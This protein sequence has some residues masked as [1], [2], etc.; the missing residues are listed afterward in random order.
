MGLPTPVFGGVRPYLRW[1][2][3]ARLEATRRPAGSPEA[4]RFL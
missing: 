3:T 1:P 4:R 2:A